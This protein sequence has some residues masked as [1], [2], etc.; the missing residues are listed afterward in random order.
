MSPSPFRVG[1][2]NENRKR[3]WR[4]D[5]GIRPCHGP[6]ARAPRGQG[7]DGEM[8]MGMGMGMVF[9]MGEYPPGG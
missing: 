6:W 5:H 7:G 3:R 2:G 8:G 9:I 1:D 4:W